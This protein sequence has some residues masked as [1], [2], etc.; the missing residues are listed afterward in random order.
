MYDYKSEIDKQLLWSF[1]STIGRS[2]KETKAGNITVINKNNKINGE[3]SS[4]KVIDKL[5]TTKNTIM[6]ITGELV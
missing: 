5:S 2:N 1:F 3:Q 6:T 4:Q